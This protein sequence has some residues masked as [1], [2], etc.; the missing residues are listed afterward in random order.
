MS[1]TMRT[2]LVTGA[3][4][5]LGLGIARKLT[6]AGYRVIGLARKR[7]KDVTEAI[8]NA[9]QGSFTFVPFDLEKIEE[10]PDLVRKL[11]KEFGPLFG[12][13][14]NAALGL[15]G[16]LAMMHNSQ[17]EQLVRLN[18]YHRILVTEGVRPQMP[19]WS[20]SNRVQSAIGCF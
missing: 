7:T 1:K 17:I 3:S 19:S 14:N 15:D 11:R 20:R 10:I 4:R 16:A 2:V 9:K 5:G 13:V 8:A 6:G 12:L 18:T